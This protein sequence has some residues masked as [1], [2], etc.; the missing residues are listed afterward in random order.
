MHLR[1]EVWLYV[2][3]LPYYKRRFTEIVVHATSRIAAENSRS[4]HAGFELLF[5]SKKQIHRLN[6]LYR[7][8]DQPTDVIAFADQVGCLGSVVLCLEKIKEYNPDQH[9]SI[10]MYKT[11]IHGVLHTYGYDHH[12]SEDA[13]QMQDAEKR[14]YR[15]ACRL[16]GMTDLRNA[17]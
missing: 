13:M 15:E 2:D 5:A 17:L 4:I 8:I 16:V 1:Y 9:P 14:A 11:M 3:G 7:S 12:N 10:A 6:A